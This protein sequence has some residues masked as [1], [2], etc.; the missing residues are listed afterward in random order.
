MTIDDDPLGLSALTDD[1][2]VEMARHVAVELGRRSYDVMTAAQAA[3][4]SE[5]EKA[6]IAA[7]AARAEAERL[8]KTEQERV[9][10][11]AEDAVRQ[12]AAQ[13]DI[14]RTQDQWA[15]KKML[16]MMVNE[17]LGPGWSMTVWNRDGND[18]RVYIEGSGRGITDRGRPA[19]AKIT[20]FATGNARDA[21]GSLEMLYVP[22]GVSK[23][24]VAAICAEAARRFN[25]MSYIS[26][27]QAA[28][29]KVTARPYPKSYLDAREAANV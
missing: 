27:S 2:L 16:A 19:D 13:A 17:T 24:V 11:E 14:A 7:Q 20:Y 23:E 5:A 15:S 25:R 8:R 28:G 4:L 1:Q 26:C 29:A 6:R 10:R 12:Q 18:K 3:I 9:A 22:A 21:P